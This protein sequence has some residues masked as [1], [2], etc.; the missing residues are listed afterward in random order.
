M[1]CRVQHALPHDIAMIPQHLEN[2]GDDQL[3]W[4][5]EKAAHIL[6]DHR[7]RSFGTHILHRSF[8]E[9]LVPLSLSVTR[10][11][12]A[13]CTEDVEVHWWSVTGFS[14]EHVAREVLWLEA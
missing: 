2:F 1:V 8:E 6:R 11:F 13:W 10:E 7:A 5:E 14:G 3:V 12:L 9:C 4:F